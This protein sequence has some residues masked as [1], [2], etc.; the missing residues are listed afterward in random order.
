M[1]IEG[2]EKP[3]DLSLVVRSQI[4]AWI[5]DLEVLSWD[6]RVRKFAELREKLFSADPWSVGPP[7][8]GRILGRRKG[9]PVLDNELSAF[10]AD[11]LADIVFPAP[12]AGPR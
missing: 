4:D 1:G 2:L 10:K 11:D 6:P 3:Y 7:G 5:A 12:R 8:D 9:L